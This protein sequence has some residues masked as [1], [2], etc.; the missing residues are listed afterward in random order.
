MGWKPG[1]VCEKYV[2]VELV[3]SVSVDVVEIVVVSDSVDVS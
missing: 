1:V 3:V 2:V